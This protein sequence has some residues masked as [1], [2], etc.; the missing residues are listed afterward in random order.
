MDFN[1]NDLDDKTEEVVHGVVIPDSS[2]E[3]E[4]EHEVRSTPG[5]VTL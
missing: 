3:H 2:F 5:F 1:L 4:H